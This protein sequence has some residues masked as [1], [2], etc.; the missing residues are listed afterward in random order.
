VGHRLRNELLGKQRAEYGKQVIKTVAV[1]LAAEFGRGFEKQNLYRMMTFA[2]R[3]PGP[4]I[5]TALRSQ[6]S[7]THL[8]EIIELGDPLRTV[9]KR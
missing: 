8:R 9:P 6:L 3:F 2:E 1:A 4:E 5:V 7:W